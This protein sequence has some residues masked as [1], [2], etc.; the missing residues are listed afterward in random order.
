MSFCPWVVSSPRLIGAADRDMLK[1]TQQEFTGLPQ[2]LHLE[3]LASVALCLTGACEFYLSSCL[4]VKLQGSFQPAHLRFWSS[5]LQLFTT[6]H[7]PGGHTHRQPICSAVAKALSNCWQPLV[8]RSVLTTGCC[9]VLLP[10][11]RRWLLGCRQHEAHRPK[12]RRSVSTSCMLCS[13][14]YQLRA[15]ILMSCMARVSGGGAVTLV[16]SPGVVQVAAALTARGI[17]SSGQVHSH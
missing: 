6:V 8:G 4:W 16:Q 2:Q 9:W 7:V 12:Q 11:L 14:T 13:L 1:L 3:L 17:L 5:V 10:C 15:C